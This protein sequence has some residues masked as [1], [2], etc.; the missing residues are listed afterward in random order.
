VTERQLSNHQAAVQNLRRRLADLQDTYAT[1]R[2]DPKR[3]L[4]QQRLELRRRQRLGQAT[5]RAQQRVDRLRQVL[6]TL[7]QCFQQRQR[8]LLRQLHRHETHSRQL[9]ARLIQRIAARDAID[10]E[11]LCRERE[12]EKHQIMLS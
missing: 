10:T 9:R 7:T 11:I 5:T 12:L 2:R 6:T 8:S 3:Q 1:Q 4:A